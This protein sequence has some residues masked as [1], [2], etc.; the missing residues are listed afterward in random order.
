MRIPRSEAERSAFAGICPFHGDCLEGIA[1][2]PAIQ[3]RWGK[4]AEQLPD[5]HPAWDVVA[6]DL[7]WACVNMIVTVSPEKIIIGGGVSQTKSLFPKI[8]KHVLERLNGYVNRPE[9]VEQIDTYII[10]PNLGQQA[11][12]KGALSLVL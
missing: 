2:G 12:L 9:I 1:S 11:G 10:P 4:P 6:S 3:A 7:A 5:D 8:R